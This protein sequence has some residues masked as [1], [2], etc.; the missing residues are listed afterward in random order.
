MLHA[1]F[2]ALE[3]QK[4]LLTIFIAFA[5][6]FDISKTSL[7]IPRRCVAETLISLIYSSCFELRFPYSWA[8]SISE[9]PRIEFKGV[10]NS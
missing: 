5:S 6:I 2:T 10:L 8:E 9:K 7:I 3:I 1:S 4:E